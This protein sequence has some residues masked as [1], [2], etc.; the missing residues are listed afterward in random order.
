MMF[1]LEQEG[2]LVRKAMLFVALE[3]AA[4]LEEQLRNSGPRECFAE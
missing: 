4:V 1:V 2:S 3:S